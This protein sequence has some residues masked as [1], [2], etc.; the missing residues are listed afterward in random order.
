VTN[1]TP[2]SAIG[3]PPDTFAPGYRHEFDAWL[4]SVERESRNRASLERLIRAR[5]IA[6][7]F[8]L[9]TR[10]VR[11]SREVGPTETMR[12]AASRL[13]ARLRKGDS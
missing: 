8:A 9:G 4:Q 10:L 7:P 3:D 12:I 13:A 1:R 6:R 5:G 11:K 2:R